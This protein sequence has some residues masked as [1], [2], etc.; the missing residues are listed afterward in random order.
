MSYKLN[1]SSNGDS[2]V[3]KENTTDITETAN[4]SLDGT[5]LIEVVLSDL[6]QVTESLK[7]KYKIDLDSQ[8]LAPFTQIKSE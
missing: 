6:G 1:V 3:E 8:P 2:V 4:V 5:N 7:F